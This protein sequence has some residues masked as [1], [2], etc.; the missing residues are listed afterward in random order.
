M[1]SQVL[2]NSVMVHVYLFVFGDQIPHLHMHLFPRY[3]GT[4]PT[5]WG[6]RIAEWPDAPLGDVTG[7]AAVCEPLRTYLA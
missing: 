2:H 7:V 1:K 6:S 5:Y 3:P 4:P